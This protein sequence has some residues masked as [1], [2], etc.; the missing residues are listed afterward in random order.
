MFVIVLLVSALVLNP[1]SLSYLLPL[2][3]ES[4]GGEV[5]G[6]IDRNFTF[7]IAVGTGYFLIVLT[8]LISRL[9]SRRRR[10]RPQRL[11]AGDQYEGRGG[12][13]R[14]PPSRR[15]GGRRRRRR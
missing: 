12:G 10:A 15:G 6:F 9:G 11:A 5:E 7:M 14:P 1:V 2:L 8:M 13:K 3:G 4:L